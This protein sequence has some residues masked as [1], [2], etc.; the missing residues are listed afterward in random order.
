MSVMLQERIAYKRQS[1]TQQW[2]DAVLR[3]YPRDSA[4]FLSR[5]QDPFT[6][7][8]GQAMARAIPV[9]LDAIVRARVEPCLEAVLKLRSLQDFSAS[10]AV[11]FVLTV[12]PLLR[13][14]VAGDGGG[15]GTDEQWRQVDARVDEIALIAFD[16]YMRCRE[17]MYEVRYKQVKRMHHLFLERARRALGED[18]P[19]LDLSNSSDDADTSDDSQR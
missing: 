4:R 16:V 10:Q 9:L 3:T 6:N 14:A 12:K 17:L 18:G 19:E 2:L 5:Q 15:R 13:E 1:V 8:A 7:P 11:G